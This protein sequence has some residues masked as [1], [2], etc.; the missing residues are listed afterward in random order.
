[1]AHFDRRQILT[2]GGGLLASASAAAQANLGRKGSSPKAPAFVLNVVDFGAM[3]DGKVDDTHAFQAAMDE[4]A[5]QG[6]GLVRVPVGTYLIKS[7]LL[8]PSD[9]TLEGTSSWAGGR[10]RKR[11]SQS[12]DPSGSVLL[13]I[14]GA[15]DPKGTPFIRMS[16]ASTLKGLSV[17]Y[18]EQVDGKPHAYPW[19]VAVNEGGAGLQA[20]IDVNLINPYQA[21]DFGSYENSAFLIRNLFADAL[22]RGIYIDQG[23]LGRLENV[24]LGHQWQRVGIPEGGAN[25][26]DDNL[27][28]KTYTASNAEAFIV[29]MADWVIFQDCVCYNYKIGF[30]F[31]RKL[32]HG[33]ARRDVDA[34]EQKWIATGQYASGSAIITGGGC[35]VTHMC[36][37]VDEVTGHEGLSVANAKFNGAVEIREANRGMVRFTSCSFLNVGHTNFPFIRTGGNGRVVFSDCSF[38]SGFYQGENMKFIHAQS[39]KIG[40][41]NCTFDSDF[42]HDG[43]K[44]Y[45]GREQEII[46]ERSVKS[47]MIMANDFSEKVVITNRSKGKVEISGNIEESDRSPGN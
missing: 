46:L 17:F 9:V 11:G 43:K 22:F 7:H 12:V 1:M 21:I 29:G 45:A 2:A 47:A 41:V 5:R 30:H 42:L 10:I 4:C 44:D 31:I 26:S 28:F 23:A 14:E 35:D 19:T 40:I 25:G 20:I 39:G 18:P 16:Q 38:H 24:Q 37:V 13:A 36:I 15:G 33:V 6:G 32:S 8:I 27:P 3:A 34:D